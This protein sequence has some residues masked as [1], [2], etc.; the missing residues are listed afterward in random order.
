[1]GADP[2]SAAITTGGQFLQQYLAQMAAREKEKRDALAMQA[3]QEQE[4]V[5]TQATSQ[6]NALSQLMGAYGRAML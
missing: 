1:M 4:A 6:Q 3:K 5:G 2:A